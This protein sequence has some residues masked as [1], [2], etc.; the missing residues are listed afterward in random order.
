MNKDMLD[1][2]LYWM[3]ERQRIY[4]AKESG[5]P[6]PWTVDP[7]LDEYKFTNVFR[8]Q[9]RVTVELT[10]RLKGL[11]TE[12]DIFKTIV[13]FRMFNWPDTYDYLFENNLIDNWNKAKAKKAL[14][15]YAKK[16][17]VFTGAYI[18]TNN[19]SPKPK[20]D[21]VCDAVDAMLKETRYII[22]Q[23]KGGDA[24]LEFGVQL[25]S[26]YPMVGRFIGYELVTDLRHTSILNKAKDIYTWA[27]PG[28]GA[29][30]GIHRLLFVTPRGQKPKNVQIDY[31]DVMQTLQSKAHKRLGK[32]KDFRGHAIEMRDIE[33]SLC[34][35]DKYCRV[36]FGEGRPRSKYVHGGKK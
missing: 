16:H 7:I 20:I 19:G 3:K 8:Q 29:M 2:F 6:S 5:R 24:S 13:I 12:E 4:V 1:I 30:R 31:Q 9:D 14:K 35:F 11:K 36:K 25:L 32:L 33:H 21:L 10:E 23:L 26:T 28:P 15:R 18:I 22:A 17:K 27:N 34:E